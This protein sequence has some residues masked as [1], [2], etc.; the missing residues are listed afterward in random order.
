MDLAAWTQWAGASDYDVARFVLQRGVAAIACLAFLSALAQ[1]PALVGER[2][3][4]PVPR[5]MEHPYARRLPVVWRWWRYTDR[6]L[7]LLAGGGA[8]VSFAL[9][10]GLPQRAPWWVPMLCFLLLWLAYLSISDVGQTFW[11]FGWE[12][13]LVE[14]LFT[15]AFLG[16]D[17]V[18]P[19]IVVLVALRWLVF[20]LEFGAGMIKMR[21]DRSWR[22]LTALYYHH[23]TQPMPNPVSR[24]A[25]LLPRPVHR[26]ETLG[27]HFVQLVVPFFLFAPQPVASIAAALVLLT[28]LW[29][30]VSG[31]FAWLN[32]ITLVLAFAAIDDRSVAAVLPWLHDSVEAGPTATPVSFVAVTVAVGVLLA[33]LSWPAAKNLVSR[34]QLMNAS[35]NRWHLA[36]A[37]GAFGSVTQQRDEVIVEGTLAEEPSDEDWQ[38]YEFRGKPGDPRR[39]PGQFAP[40]HLRL[41]WLMWFLAL[42]ADDRWFRVFVLRLLEA[43]RPTLRLLAHDPFDGEP[44]RWVRARMF[45]YRFATRAERRETGLYW[46]RRER[47]LLMAPVG[48]P[49][50]RAAGGG[51]DHAGA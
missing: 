18:A 34:R 13:L 1:F 4:L 47:Y 50:G 26:F 35:F 5:F 20:R 25:H 6:R 21:G 19:P 49:R 41:D 45:H 36:N 23:E 2:G 33:W 11:A 22:D 46:I 40:Y 10:V 44:P 8:V 32:W 12:S 7:R 38:P 48:L 43:D 15:V 51:G 39:R 14:A 3:L 37:Y 9:V 29:L 42:G 28:Q 30:V 27:S 17:D 16:S 24:T 31:N